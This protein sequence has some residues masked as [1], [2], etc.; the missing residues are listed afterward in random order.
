MQI[1]SL[2]QYV[3]GI[4]TTSVNPVHN[5]QVCYFNNVWLMFLV[6][7][8]N[9]N[10]QIIVGAPPPLQTVLYIFPIAAKHRFPSDH[11]GPEWFNIHRHTI[12][13]LDAWTPV[14]IGSDWARMIQHPPVHHPST[15]CLNLLWM[16]LNLSR[17][18]PARAHA[19]SQIDWQTKW[20]YIYD[21][22]CIELALGLFWHNLHFFNMHSMDKILSML[23]QH[24]LINY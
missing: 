15:R 9:K 8:K 19:P 20:I 12:H 17:A 4:I 24:K 10:F 6:F 11:T 3:N 22:I 13:P 14:S 23:R 16:N 1:Q 21:M 5:A 2:I 18:Q 7:K